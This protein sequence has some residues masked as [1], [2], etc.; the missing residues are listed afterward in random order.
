MMVSSWRMENTPSGG[1]NE[2]MIALILMQLIIKLVRKLKAS[3]GVQ[4]FCNDLRPPRSAI[5][6]VLKKYFLLKN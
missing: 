6:T 1:C 3:L 4:F 5:T 2:N